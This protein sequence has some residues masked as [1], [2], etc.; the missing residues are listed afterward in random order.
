MNTTEHAG[1]YCLSHHREATHHDKNGLPCCDPNLAGI[2]IPCN[3]SFL[4]KNPQ[5]AE[6]HLMLEAAIN[7]TRIGEHVA[8][9]FVSVTLNSLMDFPS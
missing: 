7:Q 5:R 2:T 1:W 9:S 3:C 6:L 8:A 4:S